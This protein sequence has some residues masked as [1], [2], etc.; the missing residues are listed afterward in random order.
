MSQPPV[1]HVMMHVRDALATDARVGEL[2]LDV[3]H[4][5]DQVVIRGAIGNAARKEALVPIAREVLA[6]YGCALGVRDETEIPA[7]GAP[8]R[9]PEQL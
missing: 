9:E 4:E 6:E 8:D 5:D 2:G 1:E 7:A 3:T